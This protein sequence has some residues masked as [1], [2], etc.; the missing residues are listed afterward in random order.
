MVINEQVSNSAEEV[1]VELLSRGV[2]WISTVGH[3]GEWG[4]DLFDEEI[5]LRE[6]ASL[7]LPPHL[8]MTTWHP[9]VEEG[10]WFA[11]FGAYSEE[12]AF[13][14]VAILDMTAR[15]EQDRIHAYLSSL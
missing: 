10:V 15:V 4:H 9:D 11:L 5:A 14:R 3:Q 12:V 1:L 7:S 13:Q 6:V 2:A 8:V